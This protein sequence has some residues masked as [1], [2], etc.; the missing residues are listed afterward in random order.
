[1]FVNTCLQ[2]FVVFMILVSISNVLLRIILFASLSLSHFTP[3]ATLGSLV[4]YL[5]HAWLTHLLKT[6]RIASD[7]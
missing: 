3:L 4:C 7:L 6:K 2:Q 5:L 1:M